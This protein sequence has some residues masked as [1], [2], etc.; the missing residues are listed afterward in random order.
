MKKTLL[1]LLFLFT[2]FN[3]KFAVRATT[4]RQGSYM[5]NTYIKM[6][7]D[8]VVKYQQSSYI[9]NNDNGKIVYCLEPF[10]FLNTTKDY[11]GYRENQAA[12]LNISEEDFKKIVASIYFGYGYQNHAAVN[13]YSVS[14]VMVWKI[15]D[16]NA[17]IYFTDTLNGSPTDKFSSQLEELERL[18][19]AYMQEPLFTKDIIRLNLG[20]EVV[21]NSEGYVGNNNDILEFSDDKIVI[22]GLREANE[23]YNLV[24]GSKSLNT[25]YYDVDN[26]NIIEVNGLEPITKPLS[27]VV[28][29]GKLK[30]LFNKEEEHYSNC[31]SDTKTTYGLYD[32]QNNLLSTID[33]LDTYVSDYL[34][35]GTYYIKQISHACN[36]LLD[37][38]IYEVEI[39]D[40]NKS[41]EIS[42]SVKKATKE[43]IINKT[44]G[45]ARLEEENAKFI[46]GDENKTYE[47]VTDSKGE[48]R[49]TLGMGSYKLKQ[50]SGVAGYNLVEDIEIN[51]L[52][53]PDNV[54][55]DLNNTPKKFNLKVQAK[56]D[57]GGILRNA[58]VCLEDN[59]QITNEDGE[60]EFLDINYGSYNIIAS[61][62]DYEVVNKLIDLDRD[63]KLILELKK[64][65]VE[66]VKLETDDLIKEEYPVEDL[67]SEEIILPN[68]STNLDIIVSSILGFGI[69]ISVERKKYVKA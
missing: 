60:I 1:I 41:P 45:E 59:C 63:I 43:I 38:D 57:L 34:P 67:A 55:L 61:L 33:F 15:M 32:S 36:T 23:T 29:A 31:K 5:Y 2:F 13:W 52:E 51:L 65:I 19:D 20:E 16:K 25:L 35:Y 53:Y 49:I 17:N 47:L 69:T 14:Q 48:A 4:M 56:D 64:I 44:Y 40:A 8:N 18:V 10:V 3:F 6:Q 30:I 9:I 11:T 58:K 66:D 21:L 50:V 42:I 68:T 22:K 54:R 37:K 7:K 27:V 62:D 26:Q 39:N 28:T 12:L 24:K 46:I